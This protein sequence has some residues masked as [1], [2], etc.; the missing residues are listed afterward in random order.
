MSDLGVHN[1]ELTIDLRAS[2]TLG[3][4]VLLARETFAPAIWAKLTARER[5][6]AT[7]IRRGLSNKAIARKLD[8]GVGTVKDHLHNTLRKAG[9][10]SRAKLAAAFG[11]PR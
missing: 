5:E 7:C 4:P 1:I 6:V 9:L 11:E 8:I 2:D 3:A 10:T